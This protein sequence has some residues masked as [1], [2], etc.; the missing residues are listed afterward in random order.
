MAGVLPGLFL[1]STAELHTGLKWPRKYTLNRGTTT[2]LTTRVQVIAIGCLL[3]VLVAPTESS[4]AK[5]IATLF[6]E[7]VTKYSPMAPDDI[8]RAREK[9]RTDVGDLRRLLSLTP[10][11]VE[12][13]EEYLKLRELERNLNSPQAN[14]IA[15]LQ[16]VAARFSS[17]QV[18]LGRHQFVVLRNDLKFYLTLLQDAPNPDADKQF[19]FHVAGLRSAI[20]N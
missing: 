6:D 1:G 17:D 4:A 11:N 10:E 2:M 16:E 7:A 19:A 13:W 3:I 5:S 8:M 20:N 15:K 14:I 12:G 18:G 9:L